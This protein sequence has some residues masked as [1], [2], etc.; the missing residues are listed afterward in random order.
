[1]EKEIKIKSIDEVEGLETSEGVMKPLIF[2]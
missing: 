1:M 2:G